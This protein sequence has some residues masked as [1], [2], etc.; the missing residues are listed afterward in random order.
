VQFDVVSRLY[1][2]LLG[3]SGTWP[4]GL[5]AGTATHHSCL[6]RIE[7]GTSLSS[8]LEGSEKPHT[9]PSKILIH[10]MVKELALPEFAQN[11]FLFI[12]GKNPPNSLRRRVRLDRLGS[13]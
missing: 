7:T 6:H 2:L 3:G 5:S 4:A 12:D 13:H 8:P 10:K 1:A 9:K 11:G